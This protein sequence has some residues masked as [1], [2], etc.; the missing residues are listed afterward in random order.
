MLQGQQK[1]FI[2]WEILLLL[3]KTA[4]KHLKLQVRAGVK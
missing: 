1:F 4:S 2:K 3:A